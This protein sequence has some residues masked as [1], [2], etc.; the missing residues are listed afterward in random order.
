M[1]ELIKL[2]DTCF[3]DMGAEYLEWSM[4]TNCEFFDQCYLLTLLKV[5]KEIY[6]SLMTLE[7]KY[8][9]SG[10]TYY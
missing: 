4:C 5:T 8:R 2:D 10:E 6:Y 1:R 3:T 9:Y 7:S